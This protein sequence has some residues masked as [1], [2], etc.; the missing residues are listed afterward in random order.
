M[1]FIIKTVKINQFTSHVLSLISQISKG[2]LLATIHFSII[3][4]NPDKFFPR[5]SLGTPPPHPGII[6]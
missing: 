5:N 1:I 3:F 2:A 6:L 4:L